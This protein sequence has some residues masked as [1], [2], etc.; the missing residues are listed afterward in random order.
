VAA[1]PSSVTIRPGGE[2]S[3]PRGGP[4]FQACAAVGARTGTAE[5]G[6]PPCRQTLW[7]VRGP[8]PPGAPPNA[9]VW[10]RGGF[11]KPRSSARVARSSVPRRRSFTVPRGSSTPAPGRTE[12]EGAKPFGLTGAHLAA[13]RRTRPE[14]VAG[15]V[16]S[17]CPGWS[18][19]EYQAGRG[20]RRGSVLLRWQARP[21]RDPPG[22]TG[23]ASASEA[24]RPL[25]CL[26]AHPL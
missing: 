25:G 22:R 18:E 8:A 14:G 21:L 16:C 19:R 6:V 17:S 13:R 1:T 12:R 24:A 7:L 11:V 9:S 15:H 3:A 20:G 10:F 26:P 4:L 23:E 5:R 2:S